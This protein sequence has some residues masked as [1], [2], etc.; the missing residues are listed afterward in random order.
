MRVMSAESQI[1][2]GNPEH[3]EDV[4]GRSGRE[5]A[6]SKAQIGSE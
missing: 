4:G 6:A 2:R 5:P 3:V 1:P